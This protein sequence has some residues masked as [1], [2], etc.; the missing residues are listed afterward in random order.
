MRRSIIVSRTCLHVFF[1]PQCLL[2]PCR[3]HGKPSD[4]NTQDRN[5][6]YLVIHRMSSSFKHSGHRSV[7]EKH[8]L[9]QLSEFRIRE[10]VNGTIA[11]G[12]GN[13]TTKNQMYCFGYNSCQSSEA[14]PLP[15]SPFQIDISLPHRLHL[16]PQHPSGP[17]SN[18]PSPRQALLLTFQSAPVC[19]NQT[20]TE[21]LLAR[22]MSNEMRVKRPSKNCMLSR[23]GFLIRL[24]SYATSVFALLFI[25]RGS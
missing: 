25:F 1:L 15:A 4:Q 19:L 8:F 5:L 13:K 14:F 17:P 12:L 20:R 3:L 22:R 16:P 23:A 11:K 10:G 21:R 2:L 18:H 7:S 24:R 6:E 9:A